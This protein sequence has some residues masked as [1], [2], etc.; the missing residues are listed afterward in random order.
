[1]HVLVWTGARSACA[2]DPNDEA[3]SGHRL[4]DKGLADCL[5][6]GQVLDSSDLIRALERQNRAHPSHVPSRF[7]DLV[8]HV[9]ILK[10]GVVA[11]VADS[12]AVQRLDGSTLDAAVES[13]RR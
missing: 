13:M 7:D 4:H 2:A 1:M 3:I 12:V 11:A 8:H 9:L 6:A 5:W 10:E